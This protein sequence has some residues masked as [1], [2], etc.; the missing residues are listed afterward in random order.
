[1]DHGYYE[2]DLPK[3]LKPSVYWALDIHLT[4]GFAALKQGYPNYNFL[5]GAHRTEVGKL[6]L[7]GIPIEWLPFAC[8]SQIHCKKNRPIIYDIAF[9]GGDDGVPRKFLLQELRERYPQSFIGQA[10]HEQ[11]SD[12]YSGAKIGFNYSIQLDINM[13]FF[14]VMACGAMLLTN[15]LPRKDLEMLDLLPGR[16]FVE[17]Q[18][19]EELLDQ[20]DYYLKHEQ[21]R[22]N[23]AQTGYD[24]VKNHTYRQRMTKVL[25]VVS[26]PKMQSL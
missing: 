19:F 9:V 18:T 12:I 3:I 8:D 6:K 5:F 4:H 7:Q 25:Q 24:R 13:R 23:I 2:R 10:S 21:E 1:V 16:D 20:L 15:A 26:Q 22:K 11:M 14:E 17:Y